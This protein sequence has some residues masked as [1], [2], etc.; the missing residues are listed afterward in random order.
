MKTIDIINAIDNTSPTKSKQLEY[1]YS[2]IR[3]NIKNYGS[4]L[5]EEYDMVLKFHGQVEGRTLFLSFVKNEI[6]NGNKE[7]K[8]EV[9]KTIF[10]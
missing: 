8:E 7:I 10:F 4:S 9:I 1:M 5:K 6:D 3:S 2:I